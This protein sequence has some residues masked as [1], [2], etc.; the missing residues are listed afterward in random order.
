[1]AE[2]IYPNELV[3]EKLDDNLYRGTLYN[4]Q[5][6]EEDCVESHSEAAILFASDQHFGC[7]NYHT[8]RV[9]FEEE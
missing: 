6:V 8:T 5:G 7:L 3:L 1:M 2:T 9:G 4:R